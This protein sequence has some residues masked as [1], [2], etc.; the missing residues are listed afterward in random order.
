MLSWAELK[1]RQGLSRSL[2]PTGPTLVPAS[3]PEVMQLPE[4]TGVRSEG[5]GTSMPQAGD[6]CSRDDGSSGLARMMATGLK[7]SSYSMVPRGCC[8]TL[9]S[10]GT[11]SSATWHPCRK[12]RGSLSPAAV[13]PSGSFTGIY[14]L[15]T[16]FLPIERA[17]TDQ[18]FSI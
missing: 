9:L 15:V 2:H 10:C 17:K 18:I 12:E 11:D 8:Y 1:D 14:G 16:F 4:L 5:R 7:P 13:M 6:F 3:A